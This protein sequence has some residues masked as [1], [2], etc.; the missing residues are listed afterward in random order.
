MVSPKKA[1][2][3]FNFEYV[4]FQSENNERPEALH[5]DVVRVTRKDSYAQLRR[6]LGDEGSG[7]GSD[8]GL[9]FR[10]WVWASEVSKS[11]IVVQ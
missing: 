8:S 9:V 7:G 5:F 3:F 6:R 2:L 11:L 1:N 10:V 4:D